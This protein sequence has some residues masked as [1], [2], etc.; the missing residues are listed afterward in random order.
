MSLTLKFK[1]VYIQSSA[2]VAGPEEANG[3]LKPYFDYCFDSIYANQKSYEEGEKEM[4]KTAILTALKKSGLS[5][6]DIDVAFGGDLTDQ[7]AVSNFL[8]KEMPYSFIGV[9]GACSTAMLSLALAATFVSSKCAKNALC[10]SSSNYGSAERQF[11]YPTEY[12]IEKKDAT[13]ITVSGAGAALVGTRATKI[14]VIA[15]TFGQVHDV[16]WTDVNDMGSPMA[17]AAFDTIASHLKHSKKTF[18]DYDLIMTG[19][20]SEVGSKIL[21]EM[22]EKEG[23]VFYNHIDSGSLVYEQG[24]KDKFSGGS[25][26]GCIAITTYGYILNKM[27]RNEIKRILLVGTGALHSKTS[28]GQKN[29]IPVV[30]HA[31]ELERVGD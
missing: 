15:C 2:A 13:T 25:G 24:E 8:A 12:G 5:S 9:Y 14:K 11:R 7:L 29:V 16:Q 10:F 3:P 22:F 27:S 23:K 6:K 1:D 19:D 21:K 26:C 30:A 4:S 20:L 18:K 28:V 17:Y 31:V